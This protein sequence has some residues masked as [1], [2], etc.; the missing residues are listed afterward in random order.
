VDLFCGFGGVTAGKK[1]ALK[2]LGLLV[3][4]DADIICVNHSRAALDGHTANNPDCLHVHCDLETKDPREVLR[5]TP[6][7]PDGHLCDACRDLEVVEP[8]PATGNVGRYIT[9]M[10]TSAPC[11]RWSN[12]AKAP[13]SR[14]QD[15]ATPDYNHDWRRYGRPAFVIEENVKQIRTRWDGWAAHVASYEADGYRVE[16]RVLNAAWWGVPQGRERLILVALRRDIYGDGP[17]PWPAATHSDPER[18]VSGTQPYVPAISALDL[19]KWAPSFFEGKKVKGPQR[20]QPYSRM[21]RARIARYI[22]S[23]GR[24]WEPLARAIEDFTGPVPLD[25]ALASCPEEEWP[26]WLKRDGENVVFEGF[27]APDMVVSQYDEGVC[28]SPDDLAMTLT[29][30]GYVRF[31]QVRAVLPLRGLRGGEEANPAYDPAER[32]SHVVVAGH[33]HGNFFEAR[34]HYAAPIIVPAHGEDKRR[35]EHGQAPRF[36]PLTDVAPTTPASRALDVAFPFIV[37]YN[38]GYG[39]G[40]QADVVEPSTTITTRPR[41]YLAA[42]RIVARA[43]ECFLDLGY[44][45]IDVL[46]TAVLQGFDRSIKLVGSL[47]V[48]QRGIGNA[49]PPPLAEAVI[50]AVYERLLQIRGVAA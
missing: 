4:E 16:V 29:T 23:E 10:W 19:S 5:T 12:A 27:A 44:R 17:A 30:A 14:P 7:F 1:R 3:G 26:S 43:S 49:V 13:Y 25:V 24:F 36:H 32:P 46:E 28:R 38:G 40:P 18:P 20:G 31:A 9:G 41:H 21:V 33:A 8:C 37:T 42:P 6:E 2:R 50:Y 11:Q 47:R 48:Q 15:R 45:Q 35:G 39:K 34:L 22:R